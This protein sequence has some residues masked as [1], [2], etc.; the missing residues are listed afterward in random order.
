[1]RGHS[2]SVLPNVAPDPFAYFSR[3]LVLVQLSA[4][5]RVPESS[6]PPPNQLN[7]NNRS[8]NKQC[9]HRRQARDGIW[10]VL[11]PPP[12]PSATVSSPGR[13]HSLKDWAVYVMTYRVTKQRRS[14]PFLW[15]TLHS[16]SYQVFHG[17]FFWVRVGDS[18]NGIGRVDLSFYFGMLFGLRNRAGAGGVAIVCRFPWLGRW[19]GLVY[20][21]GD[22][23]GW[24][25][26]FPCSF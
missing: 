15:G 18:A 11:Y 24:V 14:F 8:P 19:S 21:M 23:D 1:V 13:S 9:H 16:S 4:E 22:F 20:Q 5:R 7:T 12:L 2:V 10:L 6:D 3:D 17:Y 26:P 25:I